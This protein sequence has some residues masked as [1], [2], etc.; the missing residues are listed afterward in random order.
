MTALE[1]AQVR[2]AKAQEERNKLHL[3]ILLAKQE[4]R[5]PRPEYVVRNAELVPANGEET[6]SRHGSS[7]Q[8]SPA[9]GALTLVPSHP[10]REHDLRDYVE[11]WDGVD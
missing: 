5:D 8:S 10:S 2:V 11:P 7:S 3:E 6:G 1:D 4:R 9:P